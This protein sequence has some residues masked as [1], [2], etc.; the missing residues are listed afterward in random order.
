MSALTSSVYRW[1]AQEAAGGEGGSVYNVTN[2]IDQSVTVEQTHE[3]IKNYRNNTTEVTVMLDHQVMMAQVPIAEIPSDD[4]A[5]VPMAVPNGRTIYLQAMGV[6][7]ENG[8]PYD[9]SVGGNYYIEVQD[10]TNIDTLFTTDSDHY[11]VGS[12]REEGF[13]GPMALMLTVVN[14]TPETQTIGGYLQFFMEDTE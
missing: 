2:Q 12:A 3:T 10:R 11:A 7:D 1:G 5:R 9:G 6:M 8:D 14:N 4:R 13:D